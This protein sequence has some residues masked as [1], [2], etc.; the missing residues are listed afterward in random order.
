MQTGARAAFV[1]GGVILS[2]YPI[3]VAQAAD[4]AAGSAQG[5]LQ[6]TLGLL[7]VNGVGMAGG[8]DARASLSAAAELQPMKPMGVYWWPGR[9]AARSVVPRC[10]LSTSPKTSRKSTVWAR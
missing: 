2:L 8:A 7:L 1:Y 10:R 4:R 5:M 9:M 6:V 3:S